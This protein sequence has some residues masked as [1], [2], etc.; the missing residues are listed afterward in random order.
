LTRQAGRAAVTTETGHNEK[1]VD[2]HTQQAP[3]YA[4][5][6]QSMASDRTAALRAI[7]GAGPDDQLL[8]IACGPGSLTLDLAPHVGSATGLD[9]TPGMLEQARAAQEKRGIHSVRWVQ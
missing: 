6:T 3:A 2:Q 4:A 9:L 8:D 7:T 1:I 5:L